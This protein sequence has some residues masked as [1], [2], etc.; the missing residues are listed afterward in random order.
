[1]RT[2]LIA[3][4]LALA[5]LAGWA[6]KPLPAAEA[7]AVRHVVEA[8]LDAFRKGDAARAYSYAAPGIK[9]MY[10]TPEEFMEMVRSFYKVVFRPSSIA[11]ETPVRV[12]EDVVQPVHLTDTEGRPWIAY[13][14]MVRDAKGRWLINGCRLSRVAGQET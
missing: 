5:P 14:P 6:Q 8:Q 3:L 13:Y 12:G 1:M 10:D 11:F 2:A 9:Q 4:L 7:R